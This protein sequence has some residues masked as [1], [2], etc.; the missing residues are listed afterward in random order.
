M[1]QNEI[2]GWGLG[3][4]LGNSLDAIG[5]ETAWKNPPVTRDMIHMFANAGFDILRIPTTW[6]LHIGEGPDY[7]V[8]PVWMERV[9]E[10]VSWAIDEGMRVILNTHHEQSSWLVTRMGAMDE[11]MPKFCA[12]WKQIAE[13]FEH[14]GE[15]LVFQGM[16]EPRV[17]NDKDEWNGGTPDV[18]AAVNALNQAFVRTVRASGGNNLRRWLCI[19]TVGAKIC[20]IGLNEL[21]IPADDRVIV[22]VH[23]YTPQEF[24]LGDFTEIDLKEFTAFARKAIDDE[25]E[26]LKSWMK[27][28]DV[29]VMITEHGAVSKIM[30]SNGTRNDD[31]RADYE[32]FFLGKAHELGIPCVLW[33]NNYYTEGDQFFGLFDRAKGVCNSP[34]VLKAIMEFQ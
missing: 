31:A 11:V 33:D 20:E 14:F 5:G 6:H 24:T 3:I 16:N 18:R 22:T 2:A 32:R 13:R 29:P 10:I 30:D 4:N 34:E 8:D 19:P 25:F 26:I 28:T 1:K 7:K 9:H 15:K 21:E 17:E 23:S 27:K 12:L